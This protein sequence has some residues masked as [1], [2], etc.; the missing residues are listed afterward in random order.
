MRAFFC[1]C[2]Y[3]KTPGIATVGFGDGIGRLRQNRLVQQYL[4]DVQVRI[5]T[6][7]AG[8]QTRCSLPNQASEIE[9]VGL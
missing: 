3:G 6:F 8:S 7:M 5:R 4:L 1:F 2:T 9:V